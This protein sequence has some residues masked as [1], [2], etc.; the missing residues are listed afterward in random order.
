[1]TLINSLCPLLAQVSSVRAFVRRIIPLCTQ[2]ETV[3]GLWSIVV[4]LD[5]V[6]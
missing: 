1:M 4:A 3:N 2:K 5:A 6:D